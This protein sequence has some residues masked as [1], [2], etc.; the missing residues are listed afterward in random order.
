MKPKHRLA[1][2]FLSMLVLTL[3][4]RRFEHATE[5]QARDAEL[6]L[7]PDCVVCG[8]VSVYVQPD[9][10]VQAVNHNGS[11]QPETFYHNEMADL[12]EW[13]VRRQ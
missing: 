12:V 13:I 11:G 9:G 1:K 10:V 8:S 7:V 3:R 5:G 4:A 2:A 6:L